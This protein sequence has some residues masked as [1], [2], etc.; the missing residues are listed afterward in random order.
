M[1]DNM[2]ENDEREY[3]DEDAIIDNSI[4][5]D[6]SQRPKTSRKNNKIGRKNNKTILIIVISIIAAMATFIE[7]VNLRREKIS[8]ISANK[9]KI[10]K[11]LYFHFP[12]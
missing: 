3:I 4:V 12:I 11:S 5:V 2:F 1:D 9:P 10:I 6:Y 7:T 8:K